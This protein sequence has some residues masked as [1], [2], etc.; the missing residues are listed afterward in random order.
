M[1]K[2]V[3][4]IDH[5]N[6]HVFSTKRDLFQS[7]AEG[8]QPSVLFI[9]CS[10]SRIDP[11]LLTQTDPGELFVIRNAGNLIPPAPENSGEIATIEYALCGLNIQDIVICGHSDCGAIK[12]LLDRPALVETMP[13]VTEWLKYAEPTLAATI[14]SGA[15]EPGA[16]RLNATIEKNVLTQIDNLKTHSFVEERLARRELRIHG[17]VYKFETGDVLSYEPSSETF[18]SLSK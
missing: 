2:L 18:V 12:G 1:Q 6:R 3:K 10:D 14:E 11:C 4:G 9:T 13:R 17:W 8:Q 15:E 16:Q 7:L 5:F